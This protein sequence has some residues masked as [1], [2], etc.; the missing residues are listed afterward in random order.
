MGV[1]LSITAFHILACILA[2]LKLL[3][4]DVGEMAMAAIAF[5]DVA[6]WP[7]YFASSGLKTNV[8]KINGA[9][10]WGLLVLDIS[11]VYAGKILETFLVAMPCT[12]P[13]RE[14]L[15]LSVLKNT[16][17]MVELIALNIGKEKKVNCFV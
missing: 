5:N 10:V 2:K 1:A 8:A 17:G 16:K 4:I 9:K 14:S 13:V 11:T 12:I 3:T 15:V 7:L 6:T